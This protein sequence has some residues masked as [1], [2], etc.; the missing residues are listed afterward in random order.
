MIVSC[1]NPCVIMKNS[2]Q[3]ALTV[4]YSSGDS[5]LSHIYSA[6][7]YSFTAVFIFNGEAFLTALRYS[8]YPSYF[9]SC[10]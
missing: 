6:Q 7:A 10:F 1:L 9:Y 5:A 2:V 3:N 4:I 8:L